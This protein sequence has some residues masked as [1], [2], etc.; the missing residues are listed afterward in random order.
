MFGDRLACG[1][2]K[3]ALALG[4]DRGGS[5]AKGREEAT[6]LRLVDPLGTHL[7]QRSLPDDAQL[8]VAPLQVC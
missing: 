6:V 8:H 7:R 3:L 1:I 2:A 5:L 4:R